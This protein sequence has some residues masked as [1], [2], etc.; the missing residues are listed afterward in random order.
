MFGTREGF[1]VNVVPTFRVNIDDMT[2]LYI[3][4]PYHKVWVN[5]QYSEGDGGSY[6]KS[7]KTE[8]T[9]FCRHQA[10]VYGF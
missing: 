10:A 2:G 1:S 6:F 8:N 5:V 3:A 4:G 7:A 9:F